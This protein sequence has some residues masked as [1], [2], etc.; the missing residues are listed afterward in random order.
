MNK[1]V[2]SVAL[3]LLGVWS[4]QSVEAQV[5]PAQQETEVSLQ[6]ELPFD[7]EVV[8]GTL[9]NGFQYFIRKNVEPKNRVTMYL[10]MK[11]GSILETEKQRGL[12]HFLEHMNFNG[13]KHFPKNDLVNYFQKV[14]VRFGGDLNAYTGFDQTVYQLPIPSDN[15]E[16]LKNGLQVM[17]DWAQDALLTGEEIDKERGVI[18]EEM[19][20]GRGAAQ[21]MQ[22]KYLP[23]IFNGSRYAERLPIG[24]EQVVMNFSHDELRKFHKDWYRPDLQA[25]I[26]VGDIDVAYM[27]KEVK[28]L[29]SDMKNPTNAPKREEYQVSLLNKNQFIAVTDPENTTT[30]AQVIVKHPGTKIK[31]VE[32]LR[33]SLL[34]SVYSQMLRN[35]FSEIGQSANPPFLMASASVSGFM[36]GLDAYSGRIVAKPNEL[37]AGFKAFIRELERANK[38]GFT[39]TEFDRVIKNM[40]KGLE[41][42]YAERD[43]KTSGEY[44]SEYL[45][46]F[47]EGNAAMSTEDSYAMVKKI[48]PTLTLKEA[49][50]IGK[51][52][53]KPINRDVIITAPEKEKAQLPTEAKV[54]EWFAEVQAEN[55]TPYE[56]K[57]S[58]LPLL[59][60]QPKKGSV[61]S[62]KNIKEVD[63]EEVTLSNGIRLLLKPTDFKNDEISIYGY[64]DGGTSLY[65]DAD[66]P[67]ANFAGALVAGS[68]VGQLNAIELKKYLTGKEV[69]VTPSI[70]ADSEAISASSDKEGLKTAFELMYAYFTEPRIDEDVYQNFI[71]RSIASLA[72]RDNNPQFVFSK[73][74]SEALYGN[75][76]RR[77]P[78]EE[79]D[80]KKISK[81][82]ILQIYKERFA[83][84]S[85]FVFV[86]VGSFDKTEMLRYAEEYLGGLP[87]LG[88]KEKSKDL[89][90]YPPKKG[91]EKIVRKGKEDKAQV[92]LSYMGDYKY[93]TDSNLNMRALSS[94]L[95]IK[96]LE[97]LREE[98][99]GVYGVRANATYSKLHREM[100]NFSVNFGT[101]IGKYESLINSTL[102][103]ISKIKKNGASQT[104]IDKFKIEQKRGR[105]LSVKE[106]S[107][108]SSYLMSFYIDKRPFRSPNEFYKDLEKIT[109]KSVKKV[110]NKYLKDDILFKFIL[111]PDQVQK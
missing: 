90:I 16:V 99:S 7:K 111:L 92:T 6:K 52:Y 107:F 57:V 72:N 11:A 77:R 24:T 13:L 76:I 71:N 103:E 45:D 10:A 95:T 59:S 65:S 48:L 101:S 104:D 60:T 51:Q 3:A 94:V 36:G 26:I 38:F 2:K 53:Y 27:E 15:P 47:L 35:R 88:K 19:R 14:G 63:A 64:S 29:F 37:E 98:E 12:A 33:N 50:N 25:I 78:F 1:I 56:D 69:Y 70:G 55:L 28:R 17:R 110:A 9:P 106:N 80:F 39:E 20:G 54:E 97:R 100:F 58:T 75:T 67:S 41:T 86:I 18:M 89:G 109:S 96:L 62:R 108:W 74:I 22:D 40:N 66:F 105:E 73:T 8:T 46:Y 93:N 68:G 83:D 85:D 81:D 34:R 79:A 61:V 23:V 82:K 91:F 87:N 42:S 43:K 32:D 102:E 31:T 84:A 30:M 49:E 44:V 21:R 5:K 4:L